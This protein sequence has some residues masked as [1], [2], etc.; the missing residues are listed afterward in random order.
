M[1]DSTRMRRI[2]LSVGVLALT[3]APHWSHAQQGSAPAVAKPTGTNSQG[4]KILP[5]VDTSLSLS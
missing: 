3:V 1:I 5:N 4:K 2:A